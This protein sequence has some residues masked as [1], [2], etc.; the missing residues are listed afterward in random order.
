MTFP[1]AHGYRF[2]NA[3]ESVDAGS[4][5]AIGA[6]ILATAWDTILGR[7]IQR[8]DFS[9]LPPSSDDPQV[10][11]RG[12]DGY[13]YAT[14]ADTV[15]WLGGQFHAFTD[16]TSSGYGAADVDVWNVAAGSLN[17]DANASGLTRW[18]VLYLERVAT[19]T[20]SSPR[21]VRPA[22]PGS[23]TTSTLN[24]GVTYTT[25]WRLVKGTPGAGVPAVPA[26]S[27]YHKV[28]E[29]EVPTGTPGSAAIKVYDK[30][31]LIAHGDGFEAIPAPGLAGVSGATLQ[32]YA[33]NCVLLGCEVSAGSGMNVEMAEGVADVLGIRTTIGA[34]KVALSAA[35]ASLDRLDV[36]Y[37]DPSTRQVSVTAGTPA[38]IPAAPALVTL[39]VDLT[40]NLVP[41]AFVYVP[42]AVTTS[43]S[44]VFIDCRRTSGNADASRLRKTFFPLVNVSAD[45]SPTATTR[46]VQVQA[47]DLDGYPIAAQVTFRVSLLNPLAGLSGAVATYDT[48]EIKFTGSSPSIGTI[49][50]P[51][52]VDVSSLLFKTNSSGVLTFDV[53]N[54]STGN[55]D[56]RLVIE[57]VDGAYQQTAAFDPAAP[58][59]MPGGTVERMFRVTG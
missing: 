4:L 59:Y 15:A 42:A 32:P 55:L 26:G 5:I 9:S 10:G 1:R 45:G 58:T 20:A 13:P 2:W 56:V 6:A 46:R 49:V 43:A 17:V 21:R 14:D 51:T 48:T 12:S 39:G 7:S 41:L 25:T 30:R 44:C 31:P 38:A 3:N 34:S 22:G 36:V 19:P 54:V 29:I 40:A 28:A 18:D 16:R 11:F 33:A 24:T 57:P 47:V 50:H 52:G 53:E 37:L 35:H 8:R 23:Q 27:A